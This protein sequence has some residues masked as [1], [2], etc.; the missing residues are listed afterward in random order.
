MLSN[1]ISVILLDIRFRLYNLFIA[2]DQLLWV[3]ITLGKGS[4]DETISATSYRLEQQDKIMGKLLRP[5]IDFIF[6]LY[7]KEHCKKSALSEATG[8]QLNS[9]YKELR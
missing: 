5:A 8:R 9:Y 3:I 6:S 2:V 7:E 1:L 4:P